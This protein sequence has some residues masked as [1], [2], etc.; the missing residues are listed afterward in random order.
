MFDS[1]T[2]QLIRSAPALNGVNPE[3]LPQELTNVYAELAILRLRAADFR[4]DPQRL[5]SLQRVKRLADI[6]EAAVDTG[7]DGDARRAAAFVAATAHQMLGRIMFDAYEEGLFWRRT[8]FTPLWPLP[9]CSL[10]QNKTPT[11]E[12]PPNHSATCDLMICFVAR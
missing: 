1:A 7:T 2:A 12:K 10:C 8:Q 11:P 3:L 4:D 9:Y 6:Y 5:Q